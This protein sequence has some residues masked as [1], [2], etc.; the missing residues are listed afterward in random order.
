MKRFVYVSLFVLLASFV[1]V[2]SALADTAL[3]TCIT[4]SSKIDHGDWQLL[5]DA[6]FKYTVCGSTVL[7]DGGTAPVVNP[8]I[9]CEPGAWN[10]APATC[11][12]A[13]KAARCP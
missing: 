12:A 2:K 4:A 10:S 7:S 11:V 1:G 9:S 5:S 6:G 8:C 13:W 3:G